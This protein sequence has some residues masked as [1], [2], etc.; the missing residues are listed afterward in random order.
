MIHLLFTILSNGEKTDN[1][2]EFT[3]LGNIPGLSPLKLFH[4]MQR[5]V[6]LLGRLENAVHGQLMEEC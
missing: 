1:L 2:K 3:L 6:F 5:E 4:K